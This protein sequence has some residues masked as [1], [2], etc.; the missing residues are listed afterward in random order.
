MIHHQNIVNLK[1]VMVSKTKIYI[2]L[3]LVSGGELFYKL[4]N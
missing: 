2:V 4:G 3:E 1:D